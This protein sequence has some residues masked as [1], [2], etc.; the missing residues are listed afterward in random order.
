MNL[1]SGIICLY[2]HCFGLEANRGPLEAKG[3]A[4]YSTLCV[5]LVM[6]DRLIVD[7]A[8]WCSLFIPEP[9]SELIFPP[10]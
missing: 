1:I 7:L 5:V 8:L 3:A 6:W 9:V 4:L 2:L 10:G